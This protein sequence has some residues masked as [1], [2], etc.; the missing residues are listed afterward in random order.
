[1]LD[2]AAR[3]VLSRTLN[4]QSSPSLRYIAH[5]STPR[6]PKGLPISPINPDF[7]LLQPEWPA[8]LNPE[9]LYLDKRKRLGAETVD[10]RESKPLKI[11]HNPLFNRPFNIDVQAAVRTLFQA[12]SRNELDGVIQGFMEL[13]RL[14]ALDKFMDVDIVKV[15]SLLAQYLT[16]APKDSQ[17]TQAEDMANFFSVRGHME[18]LNSA[19]AY[20]LLHDSPDS[21][22]ELWN[23]HQAWKKQSIR[24]PAQKIGEDDRLL[25]VTTVA[26]IKDDYSI[27]VAAFRASSSSFS[28]LRTSTFI[29]RYLVPSSPLNSPLIRQRLRE[30]LHDA[31]LARDVDH[32]GPLAT[33]VTDI[34]RLA[35]DKAL[36]E[37]YDS[38]TDCL[39]RG[40]F[41]V[42]TSTTQHPYIQVVDPK[43]WSLFVWGAVQCRQVSLA[44]KIMKDMPG[45]GFAPTLDMWSV[46]LKGYAKKGQVE[47][48]MNTIQKIQA[49]GLEPDLKCL[50]IIMG[51]LFDKQMLSP[52]REIFGTIQ[53]YSPR[54][55]DPDTENHIPDL[56]VAYNVAVNGLMRNRLVT[57]AEDLVKKME[58]EGPHPD[59][60][61]YNTL[62]NRFVHMKNSGRTASTLRTIADRGLQPDIYTFTILYVGASRNGNEE[63]KKSLIKRMKALDVK[64]NNA[65]FSA[66]IASI[67]GGGSTDAIPTAMDILKKMEEERDKAIQPNEITYHTIMHSIDELVIQKDLDVATGFQLINELYQRMISRG[68]RSSRVIHHLMLRMN[69][70]RSDAGSLRVALSI[71]DQLMKEELINGDSWYI[72]LSG[73]EVRQEYNLAKHMIQ[74]LRNSSHDVRGALLTVVDRLSRY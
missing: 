52:A 53:T 36:S 41:A 68:F 62:L 9:L 31:A 11:I 48:M 56:L 8:H 16:R 30:F 37:L 18:P 49:Q 15:S 58:E 14:D 27:A 22:L 17:R 25:H 69:L 33:Q 29:K 26:A 19:M 39:D 20:H 51:A 3:K 5:V 44:E 66:A 34:G 13:R 45:Y 61:T 42:S 32:F 38:I 28:P 10:Q 60:V 12:V 35:D 6:Q 50:T 57:A 67:L 64:P 59:I 4:Y 71:F 21:I 74:V 40:V 43:L 46:L 73:L 63:M 1:M 72:L 24:K 47:S 65:L 55:E 7:Q 2:R 54:P 70:R 23:Q